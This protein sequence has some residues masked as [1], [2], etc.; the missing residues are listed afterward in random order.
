MM[1]DAEILSKMR[2]IF[3]RNFGIAPERVLPE[4]RL[5]EELGLDSLDA[6]DLVIELQELT[7]KR[8][9]PEVFKTVR[10][11]DD[12]VKVV[13]DIQSSSEAA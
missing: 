8:I 4:S 7:G 3:S 13:R 12:V 1:N 2:E 5:F 9:K 6:V 10:T 11:V